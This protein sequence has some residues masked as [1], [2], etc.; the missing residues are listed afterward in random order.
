MASTTTHRCISRRADM[1][2]QAP[3]S[4]SVNVA[5]SSACPLTLANGFQ[6]CAGDHAQTPL[7][8][9]PN[10][11]VGY[12]QNWQL[13]V[14]R[15]LPGALVMTATYLGIKGTRGMQEFLPNTYPIGA[16]N[17]CPACPVGF[18]YRTSNGNSTREAGQIQ[19]R[20]R[21]RSGFTRRS[22]TPMR[23]PSTTTRRWGRRGMCVRR[24]ARAINA[25]PANASAAD[26]ARADDRTKLARSAR[27]ARP[28]DFRSAASAELAAAIHDRHGARRRDTAERLAGNAVKEWTVMT[29]ITAGTGLPETPI[30]SR[31]RAGH[32]RYG[33]HASGL[34]RR[35][36]LS[37]SAGL[38]LNVAAFTAPAPG[39][40]GTAAPRFHHRA[41][42]S[43]ASNALWRARFACTI[44]SISTC[45][46]MQR[47]TESCRVHGWN[48]T[49]EQHD[50]WAA[51]QRNPM[52]SL[53]LTRG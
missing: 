49:V 39:Q 11:R 22:I 29:Q 10:F 27:R 52:R 50:F 12:A 18:V 38:F 21:L 7:R 48:T 44:A 31:D 43:S 5:N 23:R 37:G 51:G 36:D 8:V 4:T 24:R 19:L 16:T 42:A 26:S 14:Q 2:Q 41:R 40:W 30:L 46:W 45:A 1:A 28:F 34:D 9:D 13:R 33:H 20:R 25:S 35:S 47:I 53:Q 6:N 32:R 17:P 15:D 3:L